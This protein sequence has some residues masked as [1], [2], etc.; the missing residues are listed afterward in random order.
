MMNIQLVSSSW[1]LA[2]PSMLAFGLELTMDSPICLF[3]PP[4][5]V[6]NV[7]AAAPEPS[8][9]VHGLPAMGDQMAQ[10]LALLQG[11]RAA[12]D[13]QKAAMLMMETSLHN[14]EVTIDC[15]VQDQGKEINQHFESVQ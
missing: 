6:P 5:G 10:M 14:F 11:Q 9:L 2:D 7:S 3:S 8:Q 12:M 13:E 1:D 15:C 4:G